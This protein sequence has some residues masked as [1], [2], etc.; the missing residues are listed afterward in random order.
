M[1][2]IAGKIK[3]GPRVILGVDNAKAGAALVVE[4]VPPDI[5]LAEQ[6]TA[7]LFVVG[8][9][10]LDRRS[11]TAQFLAAHGPARL[12]DPDR[13]P[14]GEMFNFLEG[15]V[16]ELWGVLNVIGLRGIMV[17]KVR[18]LVGPYPVDCVDDSLVRGI[19]EGVPG[20][21]VANL[22]LFETFRTF[23][24]GADFTNVPGEDV[25]VQTWVF[26]LVDPCHIGFAIEV[27]AADGN[28]DNEIRKT[29]VAVIG[30]GF[31]QSVQL[32]VEAL[33]AS[34]APETKQKLCFGGYGGG[35]G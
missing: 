8:F 24:G 13:L 6:G 1:S 17:L 21:D 14:G 22:D 32:I 12:R 33:F 9:C 5:R 15:I 19:C 25:G 26:L 11:G 28:S 31:D 3:Q 2:V 29:L 30:G 35:N 16:E 20:V 34:R 27:L 10:V 4:T 23:D 18:V 7:D